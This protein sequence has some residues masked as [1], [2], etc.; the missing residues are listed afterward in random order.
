MKPHRFSILTTPPRGLS[1]GLFIRA[2]CSA[3]SNRH[4]RSKTHFFC[5]PK[6][7]LKL[8]SRRPVHLSGLISCTLVFRKEETATGAGGEARDPEG[9][10]L[11]SANLNTLF[12]ESLLPS[13]SPARPGAWRIHGGWTGE[14]LCAHVGPQ[15]TVSAIS[16]E[17]EEKHLL[18][19]LKKQALQSTTRQM[20]PISP[21]PHP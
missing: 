13:A 9:Q 5:G 4:T 7:I 2:L 3:H 14:A 1:P 19:A 18:G 12:L 10:A 6:N 11:E 21:S 16:S 17:T 15:T 20:V 8:I